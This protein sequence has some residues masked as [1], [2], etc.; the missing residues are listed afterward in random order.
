MLC[1]VTHCAGL[2]CTC[3]I[4][5]NSILGMYMQV[6][7]HYAN[8]FQT[9]VNRLGLF[10][11]VTI[12][13]TVLSMRTCTFSS[14]HWCPWAF[15]RIEFRPWTV[16]KAR[17]K[18]NAIHGICMSWYYMVMFSH[19]ISLQCCVYV[20]DG[21]ITEM[22]SRPG[23]LNLLFHISTRFLWDVPPQHAHF[24]GRSAVDLPIVYRIS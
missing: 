8:F 7:A 18:N 13:V 12:V 15:Q 22:P 20:R 9:T 23:R 3:M 4:F 24:Y 21:Y 17:S 2:V 16:A 10:M 5:T 6:H 11:F 14:C 19:L 1:K